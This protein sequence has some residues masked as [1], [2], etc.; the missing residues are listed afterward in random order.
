M[1]T[2]IRRR[3]AVTLVLAAALACVALSAGSAGAATLVSCTGD[4]SGT[5][6]PALTNTLQ[7]V[8]YGLDVSYGCSVSPTITSGTVSSSS[9]VPLS[10]CASLTAGGLRART[11]TWNTSETS[12]I[13]FLA[14][15]TTGSGDTINIDRTGTVTAGKYL[16]ALTHE[17]FTTS[18]DR[19][20]CSSTGVPGYDGS[21]EL[22][23]SSLL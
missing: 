14:V 17:S 22:T 21:V 9:A 16:G 2:S 4:E 11:I 13:T 20:V 1:S 19:S 7:T 12:T 23:I 18:I 8:T 5:F 6:S 3:S 10:S 15:A